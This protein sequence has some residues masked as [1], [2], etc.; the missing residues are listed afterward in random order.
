MLYASVTLMTFSFILS[1][2]RGTVPCNSTVVCLTTEVVIHLVRERLFIITCKN[3]LHFFCVAL[4]CNDRLFPEEAKGRFMN[5]PS[6]SLFSP[7]HWQP[8][9][10]AWIGRKNCSCNPDLG[11]LF[12]RDAQAMR[13][14]HNQKHVWEAVLQKH[15]Q[16]PCHQ[17]RLVLISSCHRS[18]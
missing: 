18:P 2:V 14:C 8:Q 3:C 9:V 16:Q 11:V 10:G 6:Q 1:E 12:L 5:K 13:S 4:S 7:F 15:D 17:T